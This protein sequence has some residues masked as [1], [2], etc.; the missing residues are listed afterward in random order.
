VGTQARQRTAAAAAATAAA[1]DAG[2]EQDDSSVAAMWQALGDWYGTVLKLADQVYPPSLD[3]WP[4]LVGKLNPITCVPPTLRRSLPLIRSN[5]IRRAPRLPLSIR[6]CV[7]T[8]GDN[9]APHGCTSSHTPA[10]GVC[11]HA[12]TRMPPCLRLPLAMRTSTPSRKPHR[13]R[14]DSYGAVSG[15]HATRRW[16]AA[17]TD[18]GSG[19]LTI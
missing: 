8:G 6:G 18:I 10:N 15:G 1:G 3:Y 2:G 12:R 7:T 9:G 19:E 16:F 13:A 5:I 11:T 17:L 4:A 14:G